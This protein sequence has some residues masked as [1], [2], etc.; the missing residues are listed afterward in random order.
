MGRKSI[1]E[2]RKEEILTHYRQVILDEGFENASIAKIAAH[3]NTQPSLIMHYFKT[4]ENLIFHLTAKFLD[5]YITSLFTRL[6]KETDLNLRLEQLLD[7][8]SQKE[9]F[10]A[11][12]AK[13]FYLIKYMA[14][15]NNEIRIQLIETLS[16]YR[17]H[18]LLFL[19]DLY[20]NNIILNSEFE[21]VADLLIIIIQGYD[22][23]FSDGVY[24]SHTKC[25][26][27]IRDILIKQMQVV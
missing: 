23:L 6:K 27:L 12:M 18:V 8:I 15:T 9:H 25:K 22:N 24:S 2:E 16:R 17:Q 26:K 5:E 7:F 13:M 11:D 21:T 14:L 4:K 3:M 10:P 1:A 19:K 20:D